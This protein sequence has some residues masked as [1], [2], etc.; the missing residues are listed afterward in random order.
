M[1]FACETTITER[2]KLSMDSFHFLA[3]VGVI[4][5]PQPNLGLTNLK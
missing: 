5:E 4:T 2:Y 3:S 1:D